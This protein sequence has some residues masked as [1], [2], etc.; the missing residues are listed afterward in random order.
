MRNLR[1]LRIP[2]M[3]KPQYRTI[4]FARKGRGEGPEGRGEGEAG[5]GLFQSKAMN[6]VDAGGRVV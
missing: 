1:E 3:R 4:V 5:W 2:S 6:E